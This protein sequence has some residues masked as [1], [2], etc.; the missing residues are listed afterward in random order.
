[1]LFNR[2]KKK[3][4]FICLKM[5]IYKLIFQTKYWR[6]NIAVVLIYLNCEKST[7]LIFFLIWYSHFNYHYCYKS[8]SLELLNLSSETKQTFKKQKFLMIP[9]FHGQSQNADLVL[10]MCQSGIKAYKSTGCVSVWVINYLL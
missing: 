1:M 8:P 9:N 7:L 10:Q 3:K 6:Q 5:C 4:V 2:L